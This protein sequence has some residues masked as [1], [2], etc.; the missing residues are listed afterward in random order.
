MPLTTGLT[1]LTSTGVLSADTVPPTYFD[2]DTN[3]FYLDGCL[4]YF[5]YIENSLYMY[6]VKNKGHVMDTF[7][8]S[9]YLWAID[10]L[11]S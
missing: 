1:A 5:S 11:D 8:F 9:V 10:P 6:K 2:V 3:T 7:S 4:E